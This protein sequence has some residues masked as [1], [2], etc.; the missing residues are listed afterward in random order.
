MGG[1]VFMPK[2]HLVQVRFSKEQRQKAAINAEIKG[3]TSLSQY[4][5]ELAVNH[6]DSLT[7]KIF[8]IHKKLMKEE[9]AEA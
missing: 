6:D 4:I 3:Y 5:R 9:G 1:L 7:R 2:N 8:E